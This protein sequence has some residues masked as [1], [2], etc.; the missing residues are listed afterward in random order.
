MT[1]KDFQK[2]R[3]ENITVAVQQLAF[4][5]QNAAKKGADAN[6]VNKSIVSVITA[7]HDEGMLLATEQKNNK[8]EV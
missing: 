2:R 4:V 1:S 7:A 3:V 5:I 6:E 8:N